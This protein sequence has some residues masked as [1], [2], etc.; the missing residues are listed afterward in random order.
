MSERARIVGVL[1]V[2]VL[3]VA[4][5]PVGGQSVPLAEI[6]GVSISGSGVIDAGT[7]PGST[8][9]WN[10]EPVNVS[11]TVTDRPA[12]N[13]P[14]NGNYGVCLRYQR[15][16]G[17]PQKLAECAPLSL[18]SGANGTVTFDN[19]TWP[20]NATGEQE[21]VVGLRNRSIRANTTVLDRNP[22]PVT[23]LRKDGD[24]DSDG[25]T[26]TREVEAGYNVSNPD[27]D[28]DGIQDGAEGQ[29][30]G[31][32]PQ[33]AD[34]D[35]DGIRDGVEIQRGTNPN[36]ADTDGDGLSD[37]TER[38]FGTNAKSDLTPVWLVGIALV[39]VLIA[40]GLLVALRRGW[41]RILGD[42]GETATNESEP[43]AAETGPSSEPEADPPTVASEPLTDA[44]RVRGLLREH[45]GRMKQ[46]QIV[47]QTEWSKAKVSR[48]LSSMAEEGS[49]EKLS[50]GRE[51]VI[52][53]AD[54]DA[55]GSSPEENASD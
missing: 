39:V 7:P 12:A 33:K 25:L 40:A 49:I 36:D 38:T 28:S 24:F 3:V 35:G 4:A 19:V 21:L 26:N 31:T 5:V 29:K 43:K 17:R 51:N 41:H 42:R 52:S 50:I 45:G 2:V 18:P 34:S 20:S 16:K 32:N 1:G 54:P 46:S 13:A 8:Y 11:V 14:K 30:Y 10:D 23:V 47:D 22:V 6:D 48:L 55:G 53:L 27:M 9:L 37:S 15:G 44:D